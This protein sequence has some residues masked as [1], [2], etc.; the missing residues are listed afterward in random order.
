MEA[1][2]GLKRRTYD[3]ESFGQQLLVR[4]D[5]LLVYSLLAGKAFQTYATTMT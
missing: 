5:T 1:Y 3:D 2:D 4:F